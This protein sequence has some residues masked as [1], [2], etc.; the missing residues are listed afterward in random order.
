MLVHPAAP[1]RNTKPQK[2]SQNFCSPPAPFTCFKSSPLHHV[3]RREMECGAGLEP[4]QE[5]DGYTANYLGT[6]PIFN[7]PN[8]YQGYVCMNWGMREQIGSQISLHTVSS[9]RNSEGSCVHNGDMVIIYNP[10]IQLDDSRFVDGGGEL[11]RLQL[12]DVGSATLTGL[13]PA[14]VARSGNGEPLP[15]SRARHNN[16][17][18][19]SVIMESLDPAVSC[20]LTLSGSAPILQTH[21][22]H[23]YVQEQ[24]IT[25]QS[26]AKPLS[27]TR[28]ILFML[29]GILHIDGRILISVSHRIAWP[30]PDLPLNYCLKVPLR[31]SDALSRE[32]PGEPR[33]EHRCRGDDRAE[34]GLPRSAENLP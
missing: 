28:I 4:R 16:G 21:D 15:F 33:N 8:G 18:Q 25:P 17:V 26:Y 5:V 12:S 3:Q 34:R 30:Q 11:N 23:Q 19:D 20:S 6:I 14:G 32:H 2:D 7:D 9:A 29:P 27:S 13:P 22:G 31:R 24:Q 1:T 10:P